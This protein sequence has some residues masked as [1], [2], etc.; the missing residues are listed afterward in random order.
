MLGFDISDKSNLVILPKSKKIINKRSV[1]ITTEDFFDFIDYLKEKKSS[2]RSLNHM[3]RMVY[4]LLMI[5]FYTGARP[6]EILALSVDDI[7]DGYISINKSVGTSYKKEC[8]IIPTKTSQSIRNIPIHHELQPILNKL[9][10]EQKTSPLLTTIQGNIININYISSLIYEL[11]RECEIP[12]NA[13]MLRH[14][15]ATNLIKNN[16]SPRTVQDI[17]GHASFGMSVEYARSTDEDKEK[18]LNLIKKA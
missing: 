10:Y 11:S 12:F 18:A 15:V 17:L 5:M 4:Y 13:Y 16:T 7:K 9:V 3:Y 6:A 2:K 1:T 14:S 8:A